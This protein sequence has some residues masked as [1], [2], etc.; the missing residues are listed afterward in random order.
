V[1]VEPVKVA[2]VSCFRLT[3]KQVAPE[4]EDRLIVHVHGG[5]FVFYAGVAGTGEGV[6]LADACKAPVLSIDYRMPPDHPFPAAADD[7]LAVWR[8]VTGRRDSSKLA[9]GGTSAG[10]GLIMTTLLRLKRHDLPKPAAVFLGSPA[11]DLSKT[12]DSMFLNAE[13]DNL[14]GRYR[15]KLE[16][17]IKLYANGRP[18][19][20]PL[21]SPVYGDLSG[22]PPTI[23]LSGTRDLLLSDTIRAQRKLRRAGVTAELHVFEG[24][25]HAAFLTSFPSPESRQAMHE[26]ALFFDRQFER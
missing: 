14:L 18:L 12:G 22:F 1:K 24:M 21:L 6:L 3:P 26:V 4:N 17:C 8:A 2:G 7:V 25:S 9:L 20:A 10:G 11:C 5:S 13:V 23:L 19:K 15:G 16:D